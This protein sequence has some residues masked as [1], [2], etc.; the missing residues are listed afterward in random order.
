MKLDVPQQFDPR[1]NSA[2]S[3]GGLPFHRR[4][5]SG[6]PDPVLDMDAAGLDR[7]LADGLVRAVLSRPGAGHA[8]TGRHRGGAGRRQGLAGE[9]GVAAG[10]TWARRPA[11]TAH[12][13]L[14]ERV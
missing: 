2:D 11:V 9:S 10:R 6:Q 12:F 5:C 1:A 14:H 13:D 4:F 7:H 3:P 8:G